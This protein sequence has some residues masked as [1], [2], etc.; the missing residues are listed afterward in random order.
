MDLWHYL[1]SKANAKLMIISLQLHFAQYLWYICW[2]NVMTREISMKEK[3]RI[4]ESTIYTMNAVNAF[5]CSWRVIKCIY[6]PLGVSFCSFKSFALFCSESKQSNHYSFLSTAFNFR[7][8]I[9]LR[10]VLDRNNE[11]Q[12]C[13]LFA[14][15]STHQRKNG[16]KNQRI[17]TNSKNMKN[18]PLP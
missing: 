4:T 9:R 12:E 15:N 3:K 7:L 16:P 14:I 11:L 6:Y 18:I 13:E 5:Y 8:L 10:I 2:I 1:H 17:T